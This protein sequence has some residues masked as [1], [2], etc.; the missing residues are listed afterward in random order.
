M[1]AHWACSW[2]L[3]ELASTMRTKP[4]EEGITKWI[5][6]GEVCMLKSCKFSL[7]SSILPKSITSAYMNNCI[8]DAHLP[9]TNSSFEHASSTDN[10]DHWLLLR[11]LYFVHWIFTMYFLFLDI[12]FSVNNIESI[13]LEL[14]LLLKANRIVLFLQTIIM[15]Q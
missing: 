3:S 15:T 8:H 9:S 6:S 2:T 7:I 12:Q 1:L 11:W 5:K 13:W 10:A 4:G 14:K